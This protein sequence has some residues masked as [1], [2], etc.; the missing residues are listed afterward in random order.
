MESTVGVP[1]ISPVDASIETP[2]GNAGWISQL[3]TAPPR[4]VGVPVVMDKST[5]S[6]YGLPVYET[7]DGIISI[8][9][10]SIVV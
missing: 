5:V 1:L 3:S 7:D 10:M 6:T 9:V 2:V 8:T 4:W